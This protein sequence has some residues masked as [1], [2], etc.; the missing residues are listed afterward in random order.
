M[1]HVYSE[2]PEIP[3]ISVFGLEAILAIVVGTMFCCC[4]ACLIF[5]TNNLEVMVKKL[6]EK[7]PSLKFFTE[8]AFPS[9]QSAPRIHSDDCCLCCNPIS[10]E[11]GALCGHIFCGRKCIKRIT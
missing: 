7:Y 4:N 10:N 5:K 1:Q 11:V 9:P 6:A 8:R 3:R 2:I